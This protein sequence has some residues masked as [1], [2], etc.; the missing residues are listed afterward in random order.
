LLLQL[1]L[2]NITPKGQTKVQNKHTDTH[3]TGGLLITEGCVVSP[4]TPYEQAPGIY[5]PEQEAEWAKI[6][7]SVHNKGCKISLQLWHLGRL[8]HESWATHPFLK[9]LGRPLGSVSS[10][11]TA[12]KAYTR[13]IKGQKVAYTAPRELTAEEI[14]GR[15]VNDF[16]L[17]AEAAKR[18]NFDFV[19]IHAAHGYLFDQFF[20]DGVNK[21]TDEFGT[22]NLE[23]RTRALAGVLR[24]VIDVLGSQRVG[25]RISPTYSDSWSYQGCDDS[26]PEKTYP[27][28][29]SWLDQ[30][31][32]AYLL[33]SEPRWS[34]GR[35]NNNPVTDPTYSLQMRNTWARNLY[36]GVLIGSSSFTPATADAA[37]HEGIYDAIAFGRFFISNPDYVERAR[38]NSPI[39]VYDTRTFYTKDAKGYTDYPVLGTSSEYPVIKF[40]E[41]GVKAKL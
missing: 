36:S 8:S 30:W 19:E 3:L 34:G 1:S 25:I 26:Q 23:N 40:E 14:R 21:R 32:L 2:T 39:N 13:D 22:Q 16:R 11:P 4:E 12:Y 24:A 6:V 10:S 7:K 29:V 5:T 27:E 33:L 18:C 17:A 35:T 37:I 15:L 20:C 28:I 31:K 41:I 38:T 9:S